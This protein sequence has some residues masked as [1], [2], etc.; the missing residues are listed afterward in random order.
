[1]KLRR[2][3]YPY[4]F[5]YEFNAKFVNLTVDA[6]SWNNKTRKDPPTLLPDIQGWLFKDLSNAIVS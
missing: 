6:S 2:T 3:V 5:R 1:M 4:N